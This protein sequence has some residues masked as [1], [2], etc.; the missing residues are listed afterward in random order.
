MD[1]SIRKSNESADFVIIELKAMLLLMSSPFFITF[2]NGSKWKVET[3][4]LR[5]KTFTMEVL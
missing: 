4:S 1:I 5:R 3:E 2:N